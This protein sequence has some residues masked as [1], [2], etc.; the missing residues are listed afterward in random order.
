MGQSDDATPESGQVHGSHLPHPGPVPI[1]A[2]KLSRLLHL[3]RLPWEVGFSRLGKPSCL[4]PGLRHNPEAETSEDG[5][6][7]PPNPRPI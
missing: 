3:S 6:G 2:N 5:I 1:P 7:M 4:P